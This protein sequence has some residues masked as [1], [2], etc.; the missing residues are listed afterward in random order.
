MTYDPLRLE[1]APLAFR[2]V[3]GKDDDAT[4]AHLQRVDDVLEDGLTGGEV[5]V[6]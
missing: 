2:V 6:V 1:A 5:A 3:L 4:V